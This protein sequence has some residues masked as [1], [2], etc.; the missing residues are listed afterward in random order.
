MLLGWPNS[1]AYTL[2]SLALWGSFLAALVAI[3][4]SL[5]NAWPAPIRFALACIPSV[6]VVIQFKLA[7]DTL[8]KQDEIVRAAF[9]ERMLLAA[10]VTIILAVAYAPMPHAIGAPEA[11]IWLIYPLFW[12]FLG[13]VSAV[14]DRSAP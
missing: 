3:E 1:R 14:R 6:T 5:A 7:W 10:A 9:A 8:K 13:I 11:P 2:T 12:G 4:F